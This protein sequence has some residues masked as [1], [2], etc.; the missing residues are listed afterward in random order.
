MNQN[1]FLN[2]I[3]MLRGWGYEGK[4]N[5]EGSQGAVVKVKPNLWLRI[6]NYDGSVKGGIVEKT[7]DEKGRPKY[8]CVISNASADELNSFIRDKY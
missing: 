6:F 2:K 8:K 3:T 7:I 1:Q 5:V 4:H